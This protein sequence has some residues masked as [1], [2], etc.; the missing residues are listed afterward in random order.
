MKPKKNLSSPDRSSSEVPSSC[1][2]L[3]ASPQC[4]PP[5]SSCPSSV[6]SPYYLKAPVH[7]RSHAHVS[8]PHSPSPTPTPSSSSSPSPEFSVNTS[9]VIVPRGD[10]PL[11]SSSTPP[12]PFQP[13]QHATTECVDASF[14]PRTHILSFPTSSSPPS[15]S[16]PASSSVAA[17]S[18]LSSC[19]LS[20]S[21]SISSPSCASL[22]KIQRT[23]LGSGTSV[24]TRLLPPV[25]ISAAPSLGCSALQREERGSCH[26]RRNWGATKPF[27]SLST[28]EETSEKQIDRLHEQARRRLPRGSEPKCDK[29]K[30]ASQ[31]KAM[32]DRGEAVCAI[33]PKENGKPREGKGKSGQVQEPEVFYLEAELVHDT[34]K[35]LGESAAKHECILD[36][37]PPRLGGF[38]GVHTGGTLSEDRREENGEKGGKKRSKAQEKD[39]RAS[40]LYG[41]IY[42]IY[43]HKLKRR[44]RDTMHERGAATDK[45]SIRLDSERE[46]DDALHSASSLLNDQAVEC[47]ATGECAQRQILQIGA[48]TTRPGSAAAFINCPLPPRAE[49]LFR[50]ASSRSSPQIPA[51]REPTAVRSARFLVV[52]GRFCKDAVSTGR[53][54]DAQRTSLTVLPSDVSLSFQILDEA[55]HMPLLRGS[56]SL[57]GTDASEKFR[58]HRVL[59]SPTLSAG[60]LDPAHEGAEATVLVASQKRWI[61]I[62]SS[63]SFQ[64]KQQPLHFAVCHGDLQARYLVQA[65]PFLASSLPEGSEE[66]VASG[67]QSNARVP[68]S[69]YASAASS[70]AA[71]AS[72]LRS[73]TLTSSSSSLCR[74]FAS[75]SPEPRDGF[76]SSK[77]ARAVQEGLQRM[78]SNSEPAE[79][80]GRA[81]SAG[82]IAESRQAISHQIFGASSSSSPC[83]S[84]SSAGSP[85]RLSPAVALAQKEQRETR[86]YVQEKEKGLKPAS[87]EECNREQ[88]EER[89]GKKR[90]EE[91]ERAEE[92]EEGEKHAQM[93]K[94][95]KRN[96]EEEKGER[97]R[98][99]ELG[100]SRDDECDGD[101][102]AQPSLE[103]NRTHP[104]LRERVAN[105]Q[106]QLVRLKAQLQLLKPYA[107]AGGSVL[108]RQRRDDVP[109]K[110]LER[111]Q[112][113]EAPLA[114]ATQSTE[115]E[116]TLESEEETEKCR[117]SLDPLSPGG[118]SSSPRNLHAGN[119][120]KEVENSR[121]TAQGAGRKDEVDGDR[122]SQ[123]RTSLITPFSRSRSFVV[124]EG[125][126]EGEATFASCER[127]AK[128]GVSKAQRDETQLVL[129]ER[130]TDVKGLDTSTPLSFPACAE[131]QPQTQECCETETFVKLPRETA[132]SPSPGVS[133]HPS[134]AWQ[135]FP[136]AKAEASWTRNRASVSSLSTLPSFSHCMHSS[137]AARAATLQACGANK[138]NSSEAFCS[139]SALTVCKDERGRLPSGQ[140]EQLLRSP[141]STAR[142]HSSSP[143]LSDEAQR[144][145]A[146]RMFLGGPAAGRDS[147]DADRGGKHSGS[148]CG[149][150]GFG[151]GKTGGLEGSVEDARGARR[152]GE[153]TATAERC[154]RRGTEDARRGERQ[155]RG[156]DGD[157]FRLDGGRRKRR[158]CRQDLVVFERNGV[159][160]HAQ[161]EE[162]ARWE[163]APQTQDRRV[164]PAQREAFPAPRKQAVNENDVS[165]Q[166]REDFSP[167]NRGRRTVEVFGC[168]SPSVEKRGKMEGGSRSSGSS[169]SLSLRFG[170]TSQ[171]GLRSPRESSRLSPRKEVEPK[172]CA[173]WTSAAGVEKG[174]EERKRFSG[175]GHT[176]TS[177]AEGEEPEEA[178]HAT[179]G[180]D[181]P[182]KEGGTGEGDNEGE[183]LEGSQG[184]RRTRGK[185]SETDQGGEERETRWRQGT[186]QL[187]SRAEEPQA[188]GGA[189]DKRTSGQSPDGQKGHTERDHLGVADADKT[190]ATERRQENDET[191][192]ASW[193]AGLKARTEGRSKRD[194]EGSAKDKWTDCALPSKFDKCRSS[195]SF[196]QAQRNVKVR[197]TRLFLSLAVCVASRQKLRCLVFRR[198]TDSDDSTRRLC[199]PLSPVDL[200]CLRCPLPLSPLPPYPSSGFYPSHALPVSY[201]SDASLLCVVSLFAHLLPGMSRLRVLTS[202]CFVFLSPRFSVLPRLLLCSRTVRPF[203]SRLSLHLRVLSAFA[204]CLQSLA[205]LKRLPLLRHLL[206]C[207]HGGDLDSLLH[208]ELR[209]LL[210]ASASL[211]SSDASPTPWLPVASFSAS[212]SPSS[213]FVSSEANRASEAPLL[214]SSCPEMETRPV[215]TFFAPDCG[216][217]EG[218]QILNGAFP[219]SLREREAKKREDD[220]LLTC[221]QAALQWAERLCQARSGDA[222][223]ETNR[224]VEQRESRGHEPA[225]SHTCSRPLYAPVEDPPVAL[226]SSRSSPSLS[227]SSARSSSFPGVAFG[228]AS[229]GRASF[230]SS[231]FDSCQRG[232]CLAHTGS[233]ETNSMGA[234]CASSPSQVSS[235][236]LSVSPSFPI[237][238]PVNGAEGDHEEASNIGA[239]APCREQRMMQRLARLKQKL[240]K[241]ALALSQETQSSSVVSSPPS[242]SVQT[243]RR[244]QQR[245]SPAHLFPLDGAFP[246]AAPVFFSSSAWSWERP[247]PASA[248]SAS[249]L[250]RLVSPLRFPFLASGA[251]SSS[252]LPRLSSSF[253][254]SPSL[255]RAS[256]PLLPQTAFLASPFPFLEQSVSLPVSL[257]VGRPQEQAESTEGLAAKSEGRVP[258]SS[259]SETVLQTAAPPEV[260]GKL[261]E[262]SE[263]RGDGRNAQ[264]CSESHAGAWRK[265]EDA[266]DGKRF[267]PD[268]WNTR[269]YLF[270]DR[271]TEQWHLLEERRI[272]KQTPGKE[273][274]ASST[275]A[276]CLSFLEKSP[277]PKLP[278]RVSP[279]ARVA[280]SEFG[281]FQET[282]REKPSLSLCSNTSGTEHAKLKGEGEEES[283]KS[284]SAGEE[285]KSHTEAPPQLKAARGQ[286]IQGS[287]GEEVREGGQKIVTEKDENGD[288]NT[289]VQDADTEEKE[290]RFHMR[291][292]DATRD[293]ATDTPIGRKAGGDWGMPEGK[294]G[295]KPVWAWPRVGLRD[296]TQMHAMPRERDRSSCSE[297]VF[298]ERRELLDKQEKKLLS[299]QAKLAHFQ[300]GGS[301]ES[302][303]G[304]I[305]LDQLK[306]LR[307]QRGEAEH[308]ARDTGVAQT[309]SE[310]RRTEWREDGREQEGEQRGEQGGEQG[311]STRERGS[312]WS[313]R[314]DESEKA[315][316]ARLVPGERWEQRRNGET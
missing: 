246:A 249:S 97:K 162:R 140:K 150:L 26:Y 53:A 18:S 133:S 304:L 8:P 6:S 291:L 223:R 152:P 48:T 120:S 37:S 79:E 244:P 132:A 217:E 45:A 111:K 105:P 311:E 22:S 145:G 185:A 216:G 258:D 104:P 283:M 41:F 122:S 190:Q 275:P 126:E 253:Q 108:A 225:S 199:C 25:S 109:S 298:Q 305:L 274:K 158:K 285:E 206:F 123:Q 191:E 98:R 23:P 81:A 50:V 230:S 204:R 220:A 51:D 256:S 20:S 255:F 263:T 184:R 125:N 218:E 17:S 237:R 43:I 121:K 100:S 254:V 77:E 200:L 61:R 74:S 144:G 112:D 46:E 198:V 127:N 229:S 248:A 15:S 294:A 212:S 233:M 314:E 159:W 214:S 316:L 9:V 272:A 208:E 68:V 178:L 138:E 94:R 209:C 130:C 38:S 175:C 183:E 85:L 58:K 266:E 13:C 250:P 30:Q 71:P 139:A 213:C 136:P 207:L 29:E 76:V 269:A 164:D 89:E 192:E 276:P 155:S 16:F 203:C 147:G 124:S 103:T 313:R 236:V 57:S 296:L 62:P 188:A 281:D 224:V 181:R 261:R 134:D 307:Q 137:A 226:A 222:R 293:T 83:G 251:P 295:D 310:G 180:E 88:Q 195:R 219:S 114:K 67:K 189:G 32:K 78:Q 227:S 4:S 148:T 167:S 60:C 40:E 91:E 141:H 179:D 156:G 106:S 129:H 290:S 27:S 166:T 172:S 270:E 173:G 131:D 211:P 143:P 54:Q 47:S 63:G 93:E 300:H 273:T 119:V 55:T 278:R 201:S 11:P 160:Q 252:P 59:L 56:L 96:A 128:L 69:I 95:G 312:A 75:S 282:D 102:K 87:V 49:S 171:E 36:V 215:R 115:N 297:V 170:A 187:A 73:N 70:P 292:E 149:H 241:L 117:C 271:N 267:F 154:L 157:S 306:L 239:R 28:R 210:G 259:K 277:E 240:S 247:R 3:R 265:P 228:R 72:H 52:P 151:S 80:L 12:L 257:E 44:K 242:S 245:S 5:V 301:D 280:S 177:E 182:D 232:P 196:L 161:R 299:L 142:S 231:S 110:D 165:R 10:R 309:H 308:L 101:R 64:L 315:Q 146:P 193:A 92:R 287:E 86:R 202:L 194:T 168:C 221:L 116:A 21:T 169:A 262:A 34:N 286:G 197:V 39:K 35:A 2:S 268:V 82:Q 243:A 90:E 31:E 7:V 113:A 24:S 66:T 14:A 238:V 235:T 153:E 205:S 118:T 33:L 260:M 186:G 107:S 288:K 84:S 19:S 42:V 99:G 163:G 135:P 65:L 1:P 234:S 264:G 302:C 279:G 303:L 284:S 289:D 176:A 174:S